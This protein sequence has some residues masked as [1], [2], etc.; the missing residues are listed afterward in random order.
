MRITCPGCGTQFGLDTAIQMDAARSAL[1]RALKMPAPIAGLIAQYL[2]LFRAKH[3]VLAFDR[4]ERLMDEL[5]PMLDAGTVT[6]NGATRPAPI[7]VWRAALE[8]MIELRNADKLRLPLKSHG[9]LLEIVFGL[10]DKA[11]AAAER[12]T[13][14]QRRKGEHRAAGADRVD[15]LQ[16]LSRIRSD[17]E[18][19]L[20][21]R[22]ESI[23]R[24]KEIG[25]G[26]EALN[27]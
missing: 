1:L 3:R 21:N 6:R 14:Q 12:A 24:L 5:L 27:G 26:E 15:R 23:R 11:D 4:A 7:A 22:E 25:Y 17:F 2:G 8:E 9:Y 19:H 18:L 13:E 20:V 10:A 16:K